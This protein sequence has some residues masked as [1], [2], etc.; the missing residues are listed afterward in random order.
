[1]INASGVGRGACAVN[2][3]DGTMDAHFLGGWVGGAWE[4]GGVGAMEG[5]ARG[6]GEVHDCL[7]ERGCYG[8]MG[9]SS[10]QSVE[11]HGVRQL[12]T[13]VFADHERVRFAEFNVGGEVCERVCAMGVGGSELG[14]D[15]V[16]GGAGE[17]EAGGEGV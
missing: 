13:P 14:G 4:P 12:E 2:C 11:D 8:G 1:M 9:V 15:D 3:G 16:G 7:G 10:F 5:S 6:Y 17:K